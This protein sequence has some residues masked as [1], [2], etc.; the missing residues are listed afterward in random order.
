MHQ[1]PAD[2]DVAGALEA[3]LCRMRVGE[4]VE[5]GVGE[6]RGRVVGELARGGGV[7]ARGAVAGDGGDYSRVVGGG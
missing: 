7:R 4:V 2:R 1:L 6:A 3:D 5:E